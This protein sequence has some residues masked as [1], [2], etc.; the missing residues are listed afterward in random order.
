[1]VFLS[2]MKHGLKQ[3]IK[4]Y[5]SFSNFK[6]KKIMAD[7]FLKHIL[8]A[9]ALLLLFWFSRSIIAK[10]FVRQQKITFFGDIFLVVCMVILPSYI[11]YG[12][13][14]FSSLISVFI[15]GFTYELYGYLLHKLEK[16]EGVGVL[17]YFR[18]SVANS[19]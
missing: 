8:V 1:M 19:Y 10:F 15:F 17:S 18:K 6:P 2:L 4:F 12:Y 16:I 11:L 5:H 9:S 3:T 13:V 14:W 7:F